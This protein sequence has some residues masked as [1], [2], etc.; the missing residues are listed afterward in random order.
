VATL[1]RADQEPASVSIEKKTLSDGSTAWLAR[2]RAPDGARRSKQFKRK[3]DALDWE[4][5]HRLD[6]RRGSWIDPQAGR[7]TA[8]ARYARN[9]LATSVLATRL[10]GREATRS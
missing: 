9:S 6:L 2:V 4:S 10:A 1:E 5:E 7:I 3:V 8:A